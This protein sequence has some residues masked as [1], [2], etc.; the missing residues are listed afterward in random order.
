MYK[1]VFGILDSDCEQFV[2]LRKD[3]N[4]RGH[5]FKLYLP[6]SKYYVY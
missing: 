6:I 3:D 1:I 2:V 5:H 4:T